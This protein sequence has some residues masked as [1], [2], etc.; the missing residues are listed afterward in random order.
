MHSL[1]PG[2]YQTFVCP[3]RGKPAKYNSLVKGTAGLLPPVHNRRHATHELQKS[4]RKQR[5]FTTGRMHKNSELR[6]S[7][8]S[9]H[10]QGR[11]RKR[12]TREAWNWTMQSHQ[13]GYF[14][15]PARTSLTFA[16]QI[17]LF[18]QGYLT[19]Q[20]L[21]RAESSIDNCTYLRRQKD[22]AQ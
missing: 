13:L 15:E 9:P 12:G 21:Y 8:P 19:S 3:P 22:A 14:M 2:A 7:Q 18:L 6:R 20:S 4:T 10:P 16:L 5:R 1:V 11:L 17:M